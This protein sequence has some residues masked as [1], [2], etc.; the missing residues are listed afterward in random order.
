MN[1]FIQYPASK[2]DSL[3]NCATFG[4]NWGK[5]VEGE[6]DVAEVANFADEALCLAPEAVELDVAGVVGVH[7]CQRIDQAPATDLYQ[8]QQAQKVENLPI[9]T[10]TLHRQ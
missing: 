10:F 5:R 6:Q 9:R 2:C 1:R 3:I 4:A 8:V 7:L